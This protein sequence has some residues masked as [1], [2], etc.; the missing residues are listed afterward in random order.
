M[1][2]EKEDRGK[3]KIRSRGQRFITALA[4]EHKHELKKKVEQLTCYEANAII[5]KLTGTDWPEKSIPGREVHP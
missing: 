3:E 5:N 4:K 2:D 1:T